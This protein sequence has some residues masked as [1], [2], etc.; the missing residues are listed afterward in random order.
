M[1]GHAELGCKRTWSMRSSSS[2]RCRLRGIRDLLYGTERKLAS[3][4]VHVQVRYE[5]DEFSIDAARQHVSLREFLSECAAFK[6]RAADVE[7]ENVGLH[8]GRIDLDARRLRQAF[9]QELGVGVIFVQTLR[10]FFDSDQACSC[11]N[12]G[13]T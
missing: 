2:A 12:A 13:L 7:D 10:A 11:E 3:C 1:N 5:A 9:C 6:S 8:L 4:A